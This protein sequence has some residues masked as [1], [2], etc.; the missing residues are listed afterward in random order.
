MCH[1]CNTVAGCAV[2]HLLNLT[3]LSTVTTITWAVGEKDRQCLRYLWS[4]PQTTLKAASPSIN[5]S[6]MRKVNP[7]FTSEATALPIGERYDLS[8]PRAFSRGNNAPMWASSTPYA[9]LVFRT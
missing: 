5:S 9:H 8:Y 2:G 7:N 1:C 6:S 3:W 4:E